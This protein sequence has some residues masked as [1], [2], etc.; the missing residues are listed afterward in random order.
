MI[1]IG[2]IV[3][4][5]NPPHLGHVKLMKQALEDNDLAYVVIIQGEK[6]GTDLVR[7]PLPF[8]M[9]KSMINQLEPSIHVARFGAADVPGIIAE[10]LRNLY[11]PQETIYRFTIYTGSDR[12]AAYA[13]QVKPKYIKQ[14][15]DE[16]NRPD[17]E[18]AI[19][20]KAVE[21]GGA[22]KSIEGY[23]ASKV[24]DAIKKGK[25]EKAMKMMGIQDKTLYKKIKKMVLAGMQKEEVEAMITS[26]MEKLQ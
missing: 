3:G 13:N 1:K 8:D 22:S 16:L 26:I 19:D 24:R 15:K 6:T 14:I 2:I 9:K 18:I 4:R 20:I 12:V 21:R 11:A 17:L 25:D 23:S 10:I 5:L 7:N